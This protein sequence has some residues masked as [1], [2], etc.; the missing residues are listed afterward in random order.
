MKRIRD[1]FY[2]FTNWE[3]MSSLDVL[4]DYLKQEPK[5]EGKNY[6]FQCPTCMDSSED[7]LIYNEDKDIVTCFANEQH[8][9]DLLK[10][11]KQF[12]IKGVVVCES[13]NIEEDAK[14]LADYYENL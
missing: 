10:A 1:F 6:K 11:M 5:Q 14:I 7:N 3:N 4:K 2:N 12:D 9:K 13:P 8:S